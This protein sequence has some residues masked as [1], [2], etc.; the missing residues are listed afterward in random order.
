MQK[1]SVNDRAIPARTCA[2]Q[3]GDVAGVFSADRHIGKRQLVARASRHRSKARKRAFAAYCRVFEPKNRAPDSLSGNEGQV[4]LSG[5]YCL[6]VGRIKH[7][8]IVC[9]FLV[10]RSC[11]MVACF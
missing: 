2:V 6:V 11:V 8:L 9:Q 4:M 7:V 5:E 10:S 1:P 3:R